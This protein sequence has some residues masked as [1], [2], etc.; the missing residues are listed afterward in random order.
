MKYDLLG[1]KVDKD[2]L[3]TIVLG[4]AIA[5]PAWANQRYAIYNQE[6]PYDDE[7]G[8]DITPNAKLA[9]FIQAWDVALPFFLVFYALYIKSS[10]KKEKEMYTY[11]LLAIC[12]GA[13]IMVL[14]R[15]V[16]GG[17]LDAPGNK[18]WDAVAKYVAQ[19]L[20]AGSLFALPVTYF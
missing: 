17:S 18:S 6:A 5:I 16:G 10:A 4:A 19:P 2:L 20:A 9:S 12:L 13:W 8:G 11:V 7:H 1:L 14:M 3:L 15:P